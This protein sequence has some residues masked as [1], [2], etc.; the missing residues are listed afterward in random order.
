M[1]TTTIADIDLEVIDR[2]ISHLPTDEIVICLTAEAL[3]HWK[4]DLYNINQLLW[5]EKIDD[6]EGDRLKNQNVEIVGDYITAVHLWA[7][8]GH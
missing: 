2:G 1:S 8:Q 4:S 5:D 3:K 6:K 7:R